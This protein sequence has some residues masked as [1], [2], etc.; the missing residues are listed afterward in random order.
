MNIQEIHL[1]LDVEVDKS[2]LFE[3]PYI[4]PEIKDYWLNKAQMEVVNELAHPDIDPNKKGFEHGERRIDEL[5]DIVI[6]SLP[7]TPVV[8]GDTF[9]SNLPNDYFRLVRHRCKVTSLSGLKTS[10]VGGI[11]ST[12]DQMNVLRVNPFWEPIFEEPL[13]YIQGNKIIYETNSNFTVDSTILTYLKTPRKMQYGSTYSN[14]T[15]DVNCEFTSEDMQYRIINKAVSMLLE[16]FESQR[17][18]T[19]LN[20]SNNN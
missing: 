12:L 3:Y 8:E 16:N 6:T 5:K 20:E 10:E 11:Q 2:L 15:V 18:Q 17:Y 7:I 14:P 1:A 4:Q 9:K 13:F 19:N